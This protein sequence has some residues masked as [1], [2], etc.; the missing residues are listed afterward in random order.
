MFRHVLI[1]LDGS[2]AAE[3]AVPVGAFLAERTGGR[4][5]LLH[6]VEQSPPEAIHGEHHLRDAAEAEAY[7]RAVAD[8]RVPSTVPVTCHVHTARISDIV[9][10]IADHLAE[11][12]PDLIV[13]AVHGTH[14]MRRFFFGDTAQ[15][16]ASRSTV[17]VLLVRLAP[18]AAFAGWKCVLIPHNTDSAHEEALPL[19]FGL[20]KLCR[21]RTHVVMAV[22][23]RHSLS[24]DPG[25]ATLLPSATRAV[26]ALAGLDAQR[27]LDAHREELKAAGVEITTEVCRGAAIPCLRKAA[28]TVGADL[29][30]LGT[31]GNTGT[32]AFWEG[33]VAAR[34][35]SGSAASILLVP[36]APSPGT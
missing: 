27:H 8:R 3:T 31:H 22:P 28:V 2:R 4:V 13:M 33:S 23:T 5:T 24:D 1:P 26:L 18:E 9:G 15:Q 32:R 19:G 35:C 7:L 17:P 11:L 20:A 6:L 29:I 34:V 30:V 12:A 10:G 14:G 25:T 21:A 16:V 36:A